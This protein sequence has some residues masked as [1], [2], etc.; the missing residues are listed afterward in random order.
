MIDTDWIMTSS[1]KHDDFCLRVMAKYA[2]SH[3]GPL[4]RWEKFLDIRR[5]VSKVKAFAKNRPNG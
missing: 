5:L 2:P 3:N 4:Q 1:L